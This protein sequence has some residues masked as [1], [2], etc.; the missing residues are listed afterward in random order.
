MNRTGLP[1]FLRVKGLLALVRAMRPYSKLF[2]ISCT[3]AFMPSRELGW[4]TEKELSF[5]KELA[6]R[7]RLEFG[8]SRH[9]R[10]KIVDCER[11]LSGYA[12]T[13]E[14]RANWQKIDR[15]A[16]R[17]WLTQQLNQ[18][19]NVECPAISE[20][21]VLASDCAMEEHTPATSP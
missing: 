8:T 12:A 7:Q 6:S 19:R 3:G 18:L 4:N 15:H 21:P 16:I 1:R 2:S 5:L 20:T 13:L 14:A 10:N 17:E 9:G 11:A